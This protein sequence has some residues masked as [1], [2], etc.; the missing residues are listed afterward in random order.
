MLRTRIEIGFIGGMVRNYLHNT[1]LQT[2]QPSIH[3]FSRLVRKN[4]MFV[5]RV[6]RGNHMW[7]PLFLPSF[8]M[9]T[10]KILTIDDSDQ[11]LTRSPI[12]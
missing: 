3:S 10:V 1:P 7:L 11:V 8:T 2:P 9:R 12:S 5:P 6:H 4:R